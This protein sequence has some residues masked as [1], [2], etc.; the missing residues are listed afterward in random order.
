MNIKSIEEVAFGKRIKDPEY[1]TIF[2]SN[3]ENIKNQG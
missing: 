2:K 3:Q 1:N